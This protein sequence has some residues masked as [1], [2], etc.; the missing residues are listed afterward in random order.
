MDDHIPPP[1]SPR[2]TGVSVPSQ[3]EP[4]P[5]VG[6]WLQ[7]GE[8]SWHRT[9]HELMLQGCTHACS[10]STELLEM[11]AHMQLRACTAA[12][13]D[14]LL[15]RACAPHSPH[16]SVPARLLPG[17]RAKPSPRLSLHEWE[18]RGQC[19]LAGGP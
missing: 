1:R 15:T 6:D 8:M 13:T 14:A 3:G 18:V 5:L 7:K 17:P 11:C 4:C 16:P 12:H 9:W 10:M 2:G 19:Y